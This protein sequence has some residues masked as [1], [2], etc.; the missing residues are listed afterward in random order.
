M[1]TGIM[2]GTPLP[3]YA[4]ATEPWQ[5]DVFFKEAMCEELHRFTSQQFEHDFTSKHLTANRLK[6]TY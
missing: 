3:P 4:S 5:I 2:Q 1:N 6:R